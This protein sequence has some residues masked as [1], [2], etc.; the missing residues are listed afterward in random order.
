MSTTTHY[1][2]IISLV[3]ICVIVFT[4][5]PCLDRL[6]RPHAPK[7]VKMVHPGG[8]QVRRSS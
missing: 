8:Y 1:T 7:I 6:S 2:E 4:P 3:G 5:D